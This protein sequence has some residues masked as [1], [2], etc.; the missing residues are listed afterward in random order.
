MAFCD[1]KLQCSFHFLCV[2]RFSPASLT[3]TALMLLFF[4][5]S[6]ISFSSCFHCNKNKGGT[7]DGDTLLIHKAWSACKPFCPVSTACAR[8]FCSFQQKLYLPMQAHLWLRLL[9]STYGIVQGFLNP[10]ICEGFICLTTACLV[11]IWAPE[12]S[13]VSFLSRLLYCILPE[14][15]NDGLVWQKQYNHGGSNKPAEVMPCIV[16]KKCS[17]FWPIS[18]FSIIQTVLWCILSALSNEHIP[19]WWIYDSQSFFILQATHKCKT[20]CSNL[21]G[22]TLIVAYNPRN[23]VSQ[24]GRQL[25]SNFAHANNN[26]DDGSYSNNNRQLTHSIEGA[27]NQSG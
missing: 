19:R 27:Y 26:S 17:N 1:K 23:M 15:C 8:E 25:L 3:R 24:T 16:F 12:L 4:S 21:F 7:W 18:P 11:W 5:D 6:V 9:M 22:P 10:A 13:T 2:L 14:R 20:W